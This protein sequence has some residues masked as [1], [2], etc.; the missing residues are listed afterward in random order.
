VTR[1]IEQTVH[2]DDLA[3]SVDHPGW[4]MAP[5]AEGLVVSIGAD[6][7]RRRFGASA[8]VRALYRRGF[9]DPALPVL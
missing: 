4:P 5:D 7:G 9:A 8:M 3:R 2:L 6:I 1:I